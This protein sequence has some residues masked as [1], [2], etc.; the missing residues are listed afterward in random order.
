MTGRGNGRPGRRR[1]VL[2]PDSFKGSVG[3]ARA[4]RALADGWRSVAPDDDLVLRP[5][6]DGGEGTLEAFAAAH[7]GAVRRPVTVTGPSGRA[8]DAEWLHVPDGDGGTGVVELALACGIERYA[9]GEPMRPLDAS[10]A[11]LGEAVR[12]ALG[13]G[14]DRLVLAIGGSASSDG[15]A[16]MLVALGARLLDGAGRPVAAGA[17][18]LGTVASVDL[19]G[20]VPPPPG[21]AL[22][23]TDV[24]SPLLGPHGA[25]AVFAPQKGATPADV[26]RIEDALDGW[27]RRLGRDPGTPGSGAAGGVGY[28][29]AVWGA[30]RRPGAAAVTDL[31]GL[32]DALAGADLVVTG[33]GR[34]DEQSGRGKAPAVVVAAAA[35]A[36][37][38]AALV[39]G[40][41]GTTPE[42]VL[43][44]VSLVD[45]AGDEAD[46]MARPEHWLSRAGAALAAAGTRPGG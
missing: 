19:A 22:T 36:G 6:A 29:L 16:G 2:A 20:L 44:A 3:A 32:G 17:R 41:L 8:V 45:L 39:A 21:G 23:L 35:A 37:V 46:A 13:H 18:G 15:G 4:A 1:V 33:E 5:V 11:G 10:S 38:P 25:A 12:H 40:S 14:V 42:H 27:A 30:E 26:E 7:P 31:V 34:F 43:S 9:P 28:A 24:D